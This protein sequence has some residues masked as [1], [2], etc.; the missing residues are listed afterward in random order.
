[1]GIPPKKCRY[2]GYDYSITK[3]LK[4]TTVA[5]ICGHGRWYRSTT[6]K[7]SIHPVILRELT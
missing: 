6:T 4:R 5:L 2:G 3:T 1:M 7:H